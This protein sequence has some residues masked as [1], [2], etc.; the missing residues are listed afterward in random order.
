MRVTNA[1][2]GAVLCDRCKLANKFWSRG[3]GLLNRSSL[4]RGEGLLLKPESSVHCF[5]M[6]FPIDV[7]FLDG[8]GRV[9]KMYAPL[10]PWR[11]STIVRGAKQAL[12]VP[13]G[14]I[15]SS[16]TRVGDVLSLEE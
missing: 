11:T 12:E 8:E 13:E 15:A 10:R 16:D 3:I 14:T 6:R 4:E 7:L 2:T 5:F 9:L 1:R